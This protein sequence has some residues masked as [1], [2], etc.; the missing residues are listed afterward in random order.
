MSLRGGK[1]LKKL[2]LLCLLIV[3]LPLN[4]VAAQ[5]QLLTEEV[6][7]IATAHTFSGYKNRW[8]DWAIEEFEQ[9]LA[10]HSQTP[11][12]T[13]VFNEGLE[14]SLRI[15]TTDDNLV[16]FHLG[17]TEATQIPTYDDLETL[18]LFIDPE[19][20]L[21]ALEEAYEIRSGYSQREATI[22]AGPHQILVDNSQSGTQIEVIFRYSQSLFEDGTYADLLFTPYDASR[23]PI[24]IYEDEYEGTLWVERPYINAILNRLNED[25]GLDITPDHLESYGNTVYYYSQELADA[26]R[27]NEFYFFSGMRD[28]QGLLSLRYTMALSDGARLWDFALNEQYFTYFARLLDP[29]LSDEDIEAGFDQVLDNRG[30][31]GEPIV[32]MGEVTIHLAGYGEWTY[33]MSREFDGED[34]NHFVQLDPDQQDGVL[35]ADDTWHTSQVSVI[36]P[37]DIIFQPQELEISSPIFLE[38]FHELGD[39]FI[40]QLHNLQGFGNQYDLAGTV[41]EIRDGFPLLVTE[42]SERF[43]LL[44][45]M[46]ADD[47]LNSEIQVVGSNHGIANYDESITALYVDTLVQDGQIL[48]ERG[49]GNE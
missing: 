22:D 30:S 1:F 49:E 40:E 31:R 41:T 2:L 15:H 6:D 37:R 14:V 33:A 36:A 12:T 45:P 26:D 20:N 8:L 23:E 27:I 43:Y 25:W 19:F 16:E 34:L 46:D 7:E 5:E 13:I 17:F 24:N 3:L 38:S 4:H 9:D 29:D 11:A 21:D 42:D 44:V 39:S 35:I 32:E 28:D 10:F 18:V 48:F 47:L